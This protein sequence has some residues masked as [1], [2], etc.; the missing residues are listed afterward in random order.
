MQDFTRALALSHHVLAM[1][2][3]MVSFSSWLNMVKEWPSTC[4]LWTHSWQCWIILTMSWEDCPLAWFGA[5]PCFGKVDLASGESPGMR[6]F[7]W[8]EGGMG[9]LRKWSAR[10]AKVMSATALL[11]KV[12]PTDQQQQ[13]LGVVRNAGSCSS[14][15]ATESESA[16]CKILGDSCARW[17]MGS[18]ALQRAF[19]KRGVI[20]H[21]HFSSTLTVW[22]LK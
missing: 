3:V 21:S 5:C 15:R 13:H 17:S 11:L 20:D 14:S 19:G 1:S 2:S 4:S 12:W 22:I 10:Q 6:R 9:S 16:F 8:N 18:A 7:L